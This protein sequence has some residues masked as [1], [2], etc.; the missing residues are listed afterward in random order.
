MPGVFAGC[1]EQI[2]DSFV[3]AEPAALLSFL[4]FRP[5]GLL[6]SDILGGAEADVFVSANWQYMD[7]LRRA[8]LVHEPRVIARN[9]LCIVVAAEH[10]GTIAGLADL[11]KPG[12]RVVTPQSGTDPC[13]QYVQSL[14]ARAGIA[15]AM[16]AKEAAGE[17]VRSSGSGDLPRILA[18]GIAVAGVLYLSEAV[19]I[20]GVE[21]VRLPSAFDMADTIVFTIGAVGRPEPVLLARRFVDHMTSAKGQELL[22]R[23]GMLPAAAATATGRA[24]R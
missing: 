18:E 5:T 1:A 4:P 24:A 6:A 2:R 12:V 13:G 17:H 8:G 23:Q 9:R 3:R 10:A 14:F 7:D 21:V 19:S 15:A 16:A 20:P 11:A 22:H